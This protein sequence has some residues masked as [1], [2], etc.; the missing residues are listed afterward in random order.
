M[1]LQSTT[2]HLTAPA[3]ETYTGIVVDSEQKMHQLELISSPAGSR[4]LLD[5]G[6][7]TIIGVHMTAISLRTAEATIT[8]SPD[9]FWHALMGDEPVA[10]QAG[11]LL[12]ETVARWQVEQARR[13]PL[14][15]LQEALERLCT[16][17]QWVEALTLPE[18]LPDPFT[19]KVLERYDHTPASVKAIAFMLGQPHEGVVALLRQLGKQVDTIQGRTAAAS[20]TTSTPPAS[21]P[22]ASADDEAAATSGA[23]LAAPQLRLDR[24]ARPREQFRWTPEL[25]CRLEAEFLK[26]TET[27]NA[28]A[29]RAVA[30]L[31]GLAEE[32][33]NYQVYQMGLHTRRRALLQRAATPAGEQNTAGEE[34]G[35]SSSPTTV[36]SF[37]AS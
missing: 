37:R 32:K 12:A 7:A 17:G 25:K 9:R 20:T 23:P 24:V 36:P 22:E 27:S 8:V 11:F 3:Q 16:L 21:P 14:Q 28:D 33:V 35:G 2:D 4:L 6:E 5:G 30:D 13:Q 1:M 31:L 15:A 10:G 26:R 34:E 18:R 29:V 19:L